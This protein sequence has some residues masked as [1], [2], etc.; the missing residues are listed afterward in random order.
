MVGELLLTLPVPR[1]LC[2]CPSLPSACHGGPYL[3]Q[4]PEDNGERES[5]AW[6][7]EDGLR[8]DRE[9]ELGLGG[10]AGENQETS[11]LRSGLRKLDGAEQPGKTLE[12]IVLGTMKGEIQGLSQEHLSPS[13]DYS[14]SRSSLQDASASTEKIQGQRSSTCTSDARGGHRDRDGEGGLDLIKSL[15]A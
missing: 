12:N 2:P 11:T 8:D 10:P 13:S 7:Q 14:S 9:E 6:A 3:F 5:Y 4:R 15:I 1:S